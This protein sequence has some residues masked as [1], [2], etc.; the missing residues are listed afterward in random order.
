MAKRQT[1]IMKGTLHLLVLKVLA[2][3]PRHGVGVADRIE[4]TTRGTFQVSPGSLFPLLHRLEQEG[5]IAG[6]WSADARGTPRQVLPD[7]R[8][9]PAAAGGREKAL[10]ARRA[11]DRTSPRRVRKPATPSSRKRADVKTTSVSSEL[12]AMR[13]VPRLDEPVELALSQGDARPRSRRGDPGDRR[14]ARRPLRGR[15]HEPARG[16][17]GGTRRARRARRHPAGKGGGARGTHRGRPRVDSV[18]YPTTR[19]AASGT[20]PGSPSFSSS[21][22]RS[23]SARTPPSSAWSMPCCS[24][25]CPIGTPTGSSSSGSTRPIS[26]TRAGRCPVRICG[27]SARA[28]RRCT[29]FGAIWATGTVALTGEGQPEQ[30]RSALV[31]TNFFRCSAPRARSDARSARTTARRAPTRRFCSAGICSR[32]ASAAIRQSSAGRF[33]STTSRRPS[34]ASCREAFAAA[35]SGFERPRSPPG[36]AAVLARPRRAT[37]RPPVPSRRRTDAAGRHHRPGARGPRLDRRPNHRA[38]SARS[39]HSRRSRCG[40]DGVREVR[41]PLAGALGGRGDSAD[42]RVRERGER[43]RRA[44]GIEEPGKPRCG[45]ALGASRAR[46]VRQSL[47]EGLMVTSLGAAAGAFAGW[48]G[49]RALVA[50]RT[51]IARAASGRRGWT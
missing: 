47:V 17:E 12:T 36:L 31:T 23:A 48:L 29:D 25:R 1:E 24:R 13:L 3:E 16:R 21:R 44:R 18:R 20:R 8:G 42:D 34:S 40:A 22:S 6:E 41:G 43:A 46:L 28:A 50:P 7:H 14:D 37:A 4:Q 19:G 38:S 9:R 15:R 32:A 39:G 30:L 49:L 26:G 33:S 5:F 11:G 10:G 35:A 45:S 51:R 27:T 2:L